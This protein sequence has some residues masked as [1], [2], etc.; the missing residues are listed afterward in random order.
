MNCCVK[1]F[2]SLMVFV[3]LACS[4]VENRPSKTG[5]ANGAKKNANSY[6]IDVRDGQRYPYVRIGTQ[7]WLAKNM[8]YNAKGSYCL[9]NYEKNCEKYGRLYSW[10][11]AM[12]LPQEANSPQSFGRGY[13]ERQGVCPSGWHVP[14]DDD[15]K[16]L[17]DYISR[18]FDPDNVDLCLRAKKGWIS[19]EG[20]DV[21]GFSALGS[22]YYAEKRFDGA[23]IDAFFWTATE[24][25]R[26]LTSEGLARYMSVDGPGIDSVLV[27][28]EN[29]YSVRCV[30]NS[31]VSKADLEEKT[32]RI[33]EKGL[34]VSRKSQQ[35]GEQ[36]LK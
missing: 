18:K 2:V 36:N 5:A 1:I 32:K 24:K 31:N 14:S 33:E 25:K 6:I 26:G 20:Y 8:N 3:S 30:A 29:A 35:N 9:E 22:G 10:A 4:Q 23:L 16:K 12:A 21:F 15:W 11:S 34:P 28:K 17:V 13:R 27:A 7:L 19:E